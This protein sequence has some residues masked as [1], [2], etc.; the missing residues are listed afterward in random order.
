MN[1][2][3]APFWFMRLLNA[4]G[5]PRDRRA[6][7]TVP[8]PFNTDAA[9]VHPYDSPGEMEHDGRIFRRQDHPKLDPYARRHSLRGIQEQP[10]GTDI[11][12]VCRTF[13]RQLIAVLEKAVIA[14]QPQREASAGSAVGASRPHS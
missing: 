3:T 7:K 14:F 10:G 1:S 12:R 6:T 5:C 2:W 9:A 8:R 11:D 13:S 4:I